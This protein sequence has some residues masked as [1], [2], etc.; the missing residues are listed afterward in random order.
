MPDVLDATTKPLTLS[1]NERVMMHNKV[2]LENRFNTHIYFS[3]ILDLL[4]FKYLANIFK[5]DIIMYLMSSVSFEEV[6][7]AMPT[8]VISTR[9]ILQ[10]HL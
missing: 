6:R 8:P 9:E 7:Y 2:F 10:S 3:Y 5:V 4:I 1:K